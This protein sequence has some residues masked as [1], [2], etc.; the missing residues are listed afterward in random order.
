VSDV[1]DRVT[2]VA[3]VAAYVKQAMREELI[4]HRRYIEAHGE[5]PPEIRDWRWSRE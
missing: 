4:E 1:I 5:D 2:K 3:P